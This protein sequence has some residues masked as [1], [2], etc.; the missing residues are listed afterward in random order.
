MAAKKILMVA[1]PGT[2]KAR[3][4]RSL[5]ECG[6]SEVTSSHDRSNGKS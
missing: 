6:K 3:D 1:S 2:L 4:M 5:V